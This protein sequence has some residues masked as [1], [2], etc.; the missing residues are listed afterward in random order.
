MDVLNRAEYIISPNL[1]YRWYLGNGDM[2]VYDATGDPENWVFQYRTYDPYTWGPAY[3]AI[4]GWNQAYYQ[5][6][7]TLLYSDETFLYSQSLLDT[8]EDDHFAMIDNAG[9]VKFVDQDGARWLGSPSAALSSD[10][11]G[12]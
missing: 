6:G 12:L 10:N 4:Y 7:I 11:C 2:L 8:P 9:C 3:Y 1:Q 5:V